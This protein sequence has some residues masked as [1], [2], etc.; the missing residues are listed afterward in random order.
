MGTKRRAKRKPIIAKRPVGRVLPE[1]RLMHQQIKRPRRQK[2]QRGPIATETG[3]FPISTVENRILR[4]MQTLRALPDPERRFFLVK[5]GYPDFV[6]DHMDAYAAVEATVP[7]FR[8]TPTDV[9][10]YLTSLSWVRHLAREKW[11]LL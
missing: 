10:E 7:R 8:P 11:Q 4:G 9:S 1:D 3:D 5:S 6:Q 2:R